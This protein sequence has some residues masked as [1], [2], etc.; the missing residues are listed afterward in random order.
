[1]TPPY[2]L[3]VWPGRW[4]VCRLGPDAEVPAWALQPAPLAVVARTRNELS[5]VAPE[6][7]VPAG[8]MAERAFSIIAVDGP[9]PFDVTGLFAAL[10]SAIAG[11][12]ISLF[13]VATY[14]TDFVLVK[15][16][17]LERAVRALR[18]A[19]WTILRAAP[20]G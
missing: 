8:L 6:E 14:D 9:V 15:E 3:T 2:P 19:G 12:G 5:I 7:R 1:M 13:P 17:A 18:E 10:A 11:A 4:T 20:G 16:E